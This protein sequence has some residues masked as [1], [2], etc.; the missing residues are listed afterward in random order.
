MEREHLD[1]S[2]TPQLGDQPAGT[3]AKHILAATLRP[4]LTMIQI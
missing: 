2:G 4:S 3:Y 1:K